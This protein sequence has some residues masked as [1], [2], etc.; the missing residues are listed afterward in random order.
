MSNI[1]ADE[2]NYD[3]FASDQLDAEGDA[4]QD[5]Q[6]ILR[7]EAFEWSPVCHDGDAIDE[8][9]WDV[10][11]LQAPAEDPVDGENIYII[12]HLTLI[13]DDG[14]EAYWRDHGPCIIPTLGR[15]IS[16]EAESI[17]TGKTFT[18][19]VITDLSSDTP[20]GLSGL[21]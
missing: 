3:D 6:Q 9:D 17:Q 2:I 20:I 15:S 14:D 12:R 8:Q 16:A 1:N 21:Y 13:T 5:R 4:W 11:G 19:V 7:Q 10:S 18:I